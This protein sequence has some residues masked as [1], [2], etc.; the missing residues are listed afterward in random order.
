MS[1]LFIYI[2]NYK[3]DVDEHTPEQ[4]T[5]VTFYMLS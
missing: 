2:S 4:N 5:I 3:L 1:I